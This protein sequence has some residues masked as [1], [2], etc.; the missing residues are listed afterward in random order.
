MKIA[1]LQIAVFYHEGSV[2]DFDGLSY[3]IK[4]AIKTKTNAN[5]DNNQVLGMIP[6][7][8]P[9][10]IPRLQLNS[11]NNRLRVQSSLQRFD[12]FYE[13]PTDDEDINVNVFMGIV[14]EI[15]DM[16]ATLAIKIKRIGMIAFKTEFDDDAGRTIAR[17]L[18]NSSSLGGLDDITDANVMYNRKF[19]KDGLE[20][21]CHLIFFQGHDVNKDRG[22]L[23][24]QIDVSSIEN[25]DFST[26]YTPK[27]IGEAF[28]E[29]IN[30]H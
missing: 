27:V 26:G 8:A 1:Q 14:E 19:K 29:K 11:S 17:K 21:N 28:L 20:F 9:P 22:L 2:I 18:L 3:F 30:E 10:E 25:V 12:F 16:H 6:K 7:D 15:F 23:I 13:R 4:R 5:L 24:K